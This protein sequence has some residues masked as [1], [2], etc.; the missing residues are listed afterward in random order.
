MARQEQIDAVRAELASKAGDDADAAFEAE[1]QRAGDAKRAELEAQLAAAKEAHEAAAAQAQVRDLE[2]PQ[3]VAS[4][5]SQ[6][7]FV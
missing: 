4:G 6:V 7:F 2:S 5:S 1:K 3:Q